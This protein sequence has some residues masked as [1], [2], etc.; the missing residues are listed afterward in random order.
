VAFYNNRTKTQ[1][2]IV[3]VSKLAE[4]FTKNNSKNIMKCVKM[5]QTKN[6][7]IQDFLHHFFAGETENNIILI[8]SLK[9]IAI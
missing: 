6:R 8:L 1:I 3:I 9:I 4:N 5:N 7:R 2:V